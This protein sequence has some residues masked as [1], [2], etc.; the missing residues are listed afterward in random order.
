MADSADEESGKLSSAARRLQLLNAQADAVRDDLASLRK[1]LAKSRDELIGLRA[2]PAKD[3]DEQLVLAAVHADSVAQT[4]VSSLGELAHYSQHDELT[5]APTRALLFDR[6][7]TAIAMA[8]RRATRVGVLFLD[9]DHFKEINDVHGHDVGD[10]VLQ[11]VT[12]RLQLVV[13]DSDTVSRHSGDEF[14]VLLAEIAG[15]ADASSVAEKMLASLAAPAQIGPHDFRLSASVGIA[16]YPEDGADAASLI[17]CADAAMY[18][19]K[20]RGAGA[21]AMHA[22]AA[23]PNRE[24]ESPQEVPELLQRRSDAALAQHEARLRELSA[25]NRELVGAAQIAQKLTTHAEQAHQRQIRFVAKAA[26]AMRT[27]LSAISMTAALLARTAADESPVAMHQEVLKR[28]ANHLSRLIDD[29]L[30]GSFAGGGE[31]KLDC[32]V[33]EINAIVAAAVDACRHAL[34]SK[35]QGLHLQRSIDKAMLRGDPMR[36]TQVFSNLLNNASRR[37]PEEGDVWVKTS[38]AG[39]EACISVLDNGVGIAPESLPRI[40]DLFVHDALEPVD[41]P[42]LGIGLAVVKELV[43]AHGGSVEA[44][45]GGRAMGS[46]FV[47]RLPL[48]KPDPVG[49]GA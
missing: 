4:A 45:S 42:G 37:T 49:H 9:L 36:L 28:Q 3:A 30:D 5:G 47:V 16:V 14:L 40:F 25:A 17:R 43:Q 15:A 32:S 11:L 6:L 7:Q 20:R 19:S 23:H 22:D 31:F 35:R 39:E 46:E 27:P 29:L 13:R 18:E 2:A 24:T 1:E 48:L 12:R 21:F 38:I 44:R 26:H 33:L 41:D 8:H 10:Q 34:I